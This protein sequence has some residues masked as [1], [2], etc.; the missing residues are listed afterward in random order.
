MQLTLRY[1]TRIIRLSVQEV[2]ERLRWCSYNFGSK[3]RIWAY[4]CY[5]RSRYEWYFENETDFVWFCLVWLS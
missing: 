2:C 1:H 4:R 5:D 3:D